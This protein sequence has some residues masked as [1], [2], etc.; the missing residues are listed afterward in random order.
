MKSLRQFIQEAF[1]DAKNGDEFYTRLQDIE[2]ELSNYNFKNSV[3]YCNCD[4]PSFSNFWKYFKENFDKLGLKL[5]L[6]TFY[7]GDPV[8]TIYDGKHT[9]RKQIDSGR[10]QD[11][12]NIIKEYK[13][14]WVVTNPPY[15]EGAPLELTEELLKTKVKFIFCGP[16]HLLVNK[17]FFNLFKQGKVSC[18]YTNINSFSRPGGGSKNA[19]AAWF[20]NIDIDK[21]KYIGKGDGNDL[22]KYDDIDA[23]ECNPSSKIPCNKYKGK[24]G[25]PYRFLTKINR[26]Q[27]NIL[28]IVTPILNGEKKMK[29]ILIKHKS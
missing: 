25:V 20:T 3:V 27:F 5:L 13:V 22:P 26:D 16:L 28:D 24:M 1:N 17:Q 9:E 2:K 15:S 12:L 21:P 8:L 11:N 6:S 18:G 4:N 7:G 29:R 14:N 19:P 23:V 10:F